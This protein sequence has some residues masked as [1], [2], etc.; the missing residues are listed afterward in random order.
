MITISDQEFRL[1]KEYIYNYCGINLSKKKT[2]VQARLYRILMEMEFQDFSSYYNYLFNDKS[3]EAVRNIIDRLSTNHTFFMREIQH[4][5][6]F[7]DQV[8]PQLKATVKNRDLRIWSAGCSSGEEP[9]TLA[10][11][12]ADYFGKEKVLWDSRILATDISSR[13]LHKAREGVY[14]DEEISSIPAPWKRNY[15]KSLGPDRKM[16]INKVKKEVIYRKFNL[17]EKAFP[18]KKKFHVIFCRNVMIYFDNTTKQELIDRF[19]ECTEK[20]GYLFI[21]QAESLNREETQYK[22]VMPAVYRKE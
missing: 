19:Y 13:A 6:Y 18:F 4:F 14:S 20:G 9:Y 8:L 12:M 7:R 11:I 16:V 5:I 3:G 15:F 10:M 22:Y 17:I 2:L 21:G 1:L